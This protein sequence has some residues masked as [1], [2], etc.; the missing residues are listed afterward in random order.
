MIS[1]LERKFGRFS[2]PNLTLILI[3]GQVC[4]YV[5]CQQDETIWERIALVPAKVLDGELYRL[6]TFLVTP[7]GGGLFWIA[8]FWYLFYLMGTALEHHWGTFRF[9]IYLLI[10]Y[11]AT[12]AVS[13]LTPD[14]PVSNDFLEGS[15]FLAF[16]YLNPNFEVMLAFLIPVRIKWFALITWGFFVVTIVFGDWSD[17][18]NATAGVLN[19]FLFFGPDVFYN[20]RSGRR[21]MASQAKR[22]GQR[23]PAF[24]HKCHVCGL[25]DK[26]DR[27]MDFRYCS[28]CS[29]EL[30]YCSEHLRNHEHVWNTHADD[31]S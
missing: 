11:V 4:T 5:L 6:L 9:N 20:I 22:F 28:Q 14:S 21:F 25:T 27:D 29:G 13:F 3:F 1:S 17:R 15:V 7:P 30:C 16:A 8:F 23:P 2:I 31:A 24:T 12:V 26:D 18:L 19:F 10:G